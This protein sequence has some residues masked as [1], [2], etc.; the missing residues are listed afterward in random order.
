MTGRTQSPSAAW[1][2][3]IS[4]PLGRSACGWRNVLHLQMDEALVFV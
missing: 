2:P 1:W 3:R 4:P